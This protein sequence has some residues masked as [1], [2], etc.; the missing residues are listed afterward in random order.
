MIPRDLENVYDECRSRL[1][2]PDNTFFVRQLL[3][4]AANFTSIY[5]ILD[6]LDECSGATLEDTISLIRQF[7]NSGIKVFCTFRP[8]LNNLRHRLDI[9]TI[10]SMSAH[11]E[12]VRNYLSIRLNKEWRHNKCFLEQI[13]DRLTE[14]AEGK[15]VSFIFSLAKYRFLLV[16]FQL[17]Y[18]LDKEEPRDAIEALGTLPK[19]MS[20]AYEEVLARIDKIKGKDTALKILSWLFHAQRPLKMY[21]IQE[22]LSIRIQDTKLYPEYFI[23]PVQIIHYCQGL[24]ELDHT[25]QIIRF[26]HY[27]VQDF[28][29]KYQNKLLA[30]TDLAKICLTYLTFDIFECGPLL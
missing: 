2:S 30:L 9:S 19:D 21:E 23:D 12:D 1:R 16:K 7:K 22:V 25:S 24:V 11:D 10:Y 20:A 18:I 8:I 5:I 3:S 4:T 15:L 27:T 28:L 14:G 29:D 6:A 17:D 26:T 13:I